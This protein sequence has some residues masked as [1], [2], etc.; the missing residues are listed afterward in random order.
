[1][2]AERSHALLSASGAHRWINCPP[3]AVKEDKLP[4]KDTI[5]TK[6]GTIAHQIAE[7]ALQR[8][9]EKISTRK[10]NSELK[11]IKSDNAYDYNEM[12]GHAVD[13]VDYIHEKVISD[14]ATILIE[15]RLDYSAYAPE[16]FGTGDCVIIQNGILSII[17]FKYGKGVAVNAE[18][19][20]QMMLYA[21]G[22]IDMYSM[23][24]DFDQVE[25]NIFQPRINN[26]STYTM[27]L[28]ELEAWGQS[29]KP[30]A[31][32]ALKGEGDFNPGDHCQFCKLK[33][34]CKYLTEY[35]MEVIKEDFEDLDGHLDIDY[36]TQEDYAM[37]L[38]KTDMVKKWLTTVENYAIEHMLSG[39]LDVPG[40]KVVEGRSN[41][42]I[43]DEDKLIEVLTDNGFDE[44]LLF[45]RKLLSIT[46]LE[47]L[48]KKKQFDELVGDYIEKPKGKPTIVPLSDKR[49]VYTNID[50]FEIEN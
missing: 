21:L 8:Y 9:C 42:K 2:S 44:V 38:S 40:Y 45:E 39:D 24:Y 49:S 17:D 43:A 25:M 32:L 11:K 15:E 18:R 7:L 14:D 46:N 50:D 37:I 10:Y 22:A 1:M 20:P 33:P 27:S 34:T 12:I 3:S 35:C 31:E 28:E 16:G 6:E 36:L 19:N 5:Y 13:Y 30:I 48:V 4:E 26:I 47:K 41:R 29:I 23:F